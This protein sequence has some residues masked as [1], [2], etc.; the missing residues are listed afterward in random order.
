VLFLA[1]G[2]APSSALAAY[3]DL[4]ERL[5]E[6]ILHISGARV[7]IDSSKGRCQNVATGLS[8]SR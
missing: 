2:L 8:A 1:R 6:A 7:V 5:Y 4:L 3:G